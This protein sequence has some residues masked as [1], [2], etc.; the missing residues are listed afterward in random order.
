MKDG[1]IKEWN[2]DSY[3]GEKWNDKKWNNDKK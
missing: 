2:P 1:M 3:R